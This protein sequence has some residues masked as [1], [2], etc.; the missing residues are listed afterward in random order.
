MTRDDFMKLTDQQK[1]DQF[2]LCEHNEEAEPYD[3][4]TSS[5]STL[6]DG[7]EVALL[8]FRAIRLGLH[9]E[10]PTTIEQIEGDLFDTL[11]E[12]LPN[13][14]KTS[15]YQKYMSKEQSDGN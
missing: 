15:W 13:I 3:E 5:R 2:S 10:E 9:P 12:A 11:K 4:L 8:Q 1:W 14:E 6:W 7:V